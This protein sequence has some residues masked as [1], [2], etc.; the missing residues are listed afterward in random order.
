MGNTF[1]FPGLKFEVVYLNLSLIAS[2]VI[3]VNAL[4]SL[5]FWVLYSLD[6][7]LEVLITI[8]YKNVIESCLTLLNVFLDFG[9]EKRKPLIDK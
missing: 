5:V 7:L 2:I 6:S 8:D 4:K 1:S 3:A 9:E